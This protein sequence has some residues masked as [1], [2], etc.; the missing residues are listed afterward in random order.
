MLLVQKQGGYLLIR[1]NWQPLICLLINCCKE[2]PSAELIDW[3]RLIHSLCAQQA[4]SDLHAQ[5]MYPNDRLTEGRTKAQIQKNSIAFLREKSAEKLLFSDAAP[6]P[7]VLKSSSATIISKAHRS[8]GR[9]KTL[10]S[11]YIS[12]GVEGSNAYLTN[13]NLT[14]NVF[15]FAVAICMHKISKRLLVSVARICSID[16]V[17]STSIA[18]VDRPIQFISSIERTFLPGRPWL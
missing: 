9:P 17:Y 13:A 15:L 5:V 12:E 11:A 6:S 3:V 4:S 14:W 10:E 16:W 1:Q 8:V 7:D 2:L 18:F